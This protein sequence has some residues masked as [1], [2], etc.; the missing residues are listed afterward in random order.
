MLSIRLEE[1]FAS[2]YMNLSILRDS[3]RMKKN[4]RFSEFVEII[5]KLRAPDGCPWDR[6]QT[7]GSLRS[8]LIEEA[9]EVADGIDHYEKTGSY[10]NLCEELGDLLLQVIMHS[11]IAEEE[12]NFTI[13]DVITGISEKMIRRHPHVFGE[14]EANS[15]QEVLKNWEEIKK[16]EKSEEKVSDGMIRIARALPSTIRAEKVQKKAA[17]VGFDFPSYEEAEK[18]VIEELEELREARKNGDSSHQ[19]EEF[20]D[21]MFSVVNLSR[22]LQLNVENSLTNATDKFIN[23]FVSV[24]KLASLEGR[25][26]DEMSIEELDA[27]WGRIK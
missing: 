10:E 16:E 26:L 24:E 25:S 1:K 20:G 9:Y 6:E 3:E 15:S 11:V 22:F 27:L 21:L 12:E 17:K 18:K 13:D 8:C 2:R 5:R 23:R 7:H 4:Y 19:E 14:V